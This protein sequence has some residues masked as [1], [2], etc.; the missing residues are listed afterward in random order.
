MFVNCLP[1][2]LFSSAAVQGLESP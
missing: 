1:F 2:L